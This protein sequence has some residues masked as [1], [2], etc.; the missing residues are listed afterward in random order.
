MAFE[1]WKKLKNPY[2]VFE[3][4]KRAKLVMYVGDKNV[5]PH[6]ITLQLSTSFCGGKRVFADLEIGG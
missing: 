5:P 2:I 4:S 6:N 3:F 1:K